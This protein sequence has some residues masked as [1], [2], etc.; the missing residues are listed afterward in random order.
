[1]QTRSLWEE[2][3]NLVD[4]A[5]STFCARLWGS[6]A[7][8]GWQSHQTSCLCSRDSAPLQLVPHRNQKQF[9]NRSAYNACHVGSGAKQGRDGGG[10][11]HSHCTSKHAVAW[12]VFS[13]SVTHTAHCK[14]QSAFSHVERERKKGKSY[15]LQQALLATFYSA[16]Q[17]HYSNCLKLQTAEM[18]LAGSTAANLCLS[19]LSSSPPAASPR[20]PGQRGSIPRVLLALAGNLGH[21]EVP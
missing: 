7:G 1:M 13:V 6:Q 3:R 14:S 19:D 11:Q 2:L 20:S 10:Q 15:S 9:K 5:A 16:L 8:Q 12:W 17:S 21:G 4:E 18:E